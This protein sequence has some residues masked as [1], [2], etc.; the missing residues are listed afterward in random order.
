MADE[1]VGRQIV[2]SLAK[3]VNEVQP[4][5]EIDLLVVYLEENAETPSGD[6]AAKICKNLIHNR[7]CSRQFLSTRPARK[8]ISLLFAAWK[9]H[10]FRDKNNCQTFHDSN[11]QAVYVQLT[12]FIATRFLANELDWSSVTA[13]LLYVTQKLIDSRENAETFVENSMH[14]ALLPLL[15]TCQ[16]AVLQLSLEILGRLSDWSPSCRL[17]LCDTNTID[18]CLQLASDG[19]LLTQKLCASLLRILACE[20]QAR[21]QIRIYDGVPTLLGLLSVKNLRLQWHIAWTLAQLAEFVETAIEIAQRGGVGLVFAELTNLKLP[22]RSINDWI[23]MHIGLTALLAQ[24]SQTTSNQQLIINSN[25]IFLL[26]KL[27]TVRRFADRPETRETWR[28]L[29]LSIFRV[30]RFLFAFERS[31][32]MFKKVFP[33]HI[34]E[35]FVD[36]ANY[37]HELGAY[38]DLGAEYADFLDSLTEDEAA[39]QFD[40]VNLRRAALGEVGEY[41]L[42]EQ[43]G[44][45]AFGCVYTVRKKDNTENASQRLFAL[46]EIFMTSLA[47]GETDKSFGD[48]INEVKIIKQQL[49]HPNIVR[50][51]RIF[52]E[53]HRLYIVMDLVQGASLREHIVT[54]K[55]RKKL[56]REDWVWH[57]VVQLVLA[58]RYLHK[59]KKIVHRDLKPNNIMVGEND[60]VVVTDF[61]LAKQKGADYLKSAAGTIIYSCPEIVQNLP[62]NEKAD[63]WSFGCCVYEI[64]QLQAAFSSTNMLALA[65]QIVEAKFEP[66]AEVWSSDLHQLVTSCLQADSAKRFDILQVA[67]SIAPRLLLQ[68]DEFSRAQASSATNN[69]NNNNNDVFRADDKESSLNSSTSSF[70]TKKS[71]NTVSFPA[72]LDAAVR[73]RKSRNLT[74]NHPLSAGDHVK[75]RKKSLNLSFSLPRINDS[76]GQ[77]RRVQTVA[78]DK[79]TRSTSSSD[80]RRQEGLSVRSAALREIRDPV[81]VILEQILRIMV[82]TDRNSSRTLNHQRR[83]VEMFRR[84]VFSKESTPETIKK[85]L[86]ML[87]SETQEDIDLDLGFSDYRPA[88]AQTNHA[89]FHTIDQKVTRITYEQLACCIQCLLAEQ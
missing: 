6:L 5:K 35:R 43:L 70:T 84:K 31:R 37:E 36:I 62:Y 19:D 12:T 58:L 60:R 61:G 64:C 4:R 75:D 42:L 40:A 33:T 9:S 83:L 18:L 67:S 74:R 54:M 86:R 56:F 11:L 2:E 87:A 77:R 47:P 24:L 55:E 23:A 51:R 48:M 76:S 10:F 79:P 17:D 63:I 25:G 26:G 30:L 21:E 45:G 28:H 57:V 78:S 69:V 13:Q 29:Q 7:I 49:R 88:L 46:K 66:M 27:L 82:V 53:N 38:E 41:E 16:M 72:I 44:A 65:T 80:L 85:H 59:E 20:P 68:L 14:H 50:Y 22:D 1:D 81:L 3:S 32:A 39:K 89:G 8:W 34:L 52:V 71:Q 73:K 15:G